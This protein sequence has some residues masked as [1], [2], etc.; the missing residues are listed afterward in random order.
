M[1]FDLRDVLADSM[2][3]KKYIEIHFLSSNEP[4]RCM[5]Q[6]IYDTTV[7]VRTVY[8]DDMYIKDSAITAVK[9]KGE[10][11]GGKA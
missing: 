1:N 5:V 11:H 3:D 8:G 9:F 4:I 6:D 2:R 7:L 10:A